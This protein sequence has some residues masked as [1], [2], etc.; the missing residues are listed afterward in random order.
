[1]IGHL[2]IWS[3]ELRRHGD[4]GAV[5]DAAAELEEL[6]YGA[7]FIP[8]GTGGDDLFAAV[9]RLLEATNHAHVITGVI[10]VWMHTAEEVAGAAATLQAAHPGRFLAGLGISHAPLVDAQE[11][12]RYRKP[13]S[14]M[15]AYLDAIDATS[16]PIPADRRL[17]G[18]LGP[19]MLDLAAERTAGAHPYFVTTEHT[20][21]ARERLGR[22][23]LLAVEQAVV[24]ETDPIAAR[25][26]AR[27]HMEVYL[28]LPN[29]VNA[30][31]AHGATEDDVRDGGSDRLVDA[32]VAWGDEDAVAARVAEHRAAG[33]DHVCLQVLGD[34][35][36][37]PPRDAWRRLAVLD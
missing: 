7:L 20:R 27:R 13:L 24:L 37:A 4:D 1:M 19:R 6:G 12:G 35:D 5:R 9:G 18:A 34:A 11:P 21:F 25:A 29:Y 31:L 33:A 23:P 3:S 36:G 22:G 15:R 30:L 28:R 2:G 17:L 26:R 10:N 14:A 8:G 32:V 16:R